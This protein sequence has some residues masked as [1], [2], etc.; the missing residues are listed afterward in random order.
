MDT[1]FPHNLVIA[2]SNPLQL[3]TPQEHT[4]PL[5]PPL[6]LPATL[7]RIWLEAFP[8]C[9]SLTLLITTLHGMLVGRPTTHRV[10]CNNQRLAIRTDNIS[11]LHVA[12]MKTSGGAM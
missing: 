5:P 10:G 8:P 6:P 1:L 7:S 12:F 11:S 4:A 2:G 3:V 9:S